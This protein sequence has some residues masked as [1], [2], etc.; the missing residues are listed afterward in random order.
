MASIAGHSMLELHA[1]VT[2]MQDKDLEPLRER[3][4]WLDAIGRM[5]GGVSDSALVQLVRS[6][7]HA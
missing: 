7:S 6:C 1:T 5:K 4:E 2:S 3:R